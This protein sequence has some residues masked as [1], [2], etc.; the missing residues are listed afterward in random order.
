MGPSPGVSYIERRL[1]PVW[2]PPLQR[3]TQRG[4]KRER[5]LHCT[6]KDRLLSRESSRSLAVCDEQAALYLEITDCPPGAPRTIISKFASLCGL[7]LRRG[8]LDSSFYGLLWE[9]QDR[10]YDWNWLILLPINILESILRFKCSWV[11]VITMDITLTSKMCLSDCI[12]SLIV[13]WWTML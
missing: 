6:G 12:F 1:L 3:G 10:F 5:E 13:T 9:R 7:F 8:R 4:E 2:I 11:M